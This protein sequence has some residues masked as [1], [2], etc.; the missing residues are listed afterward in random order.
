MTLTMDKE[1]GRMMAALDHPDGN[2][3]NASSIIGIT[4]NN[5]TANN[6]EVEFR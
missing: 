3:E 2:G 4:V 5:Q 1:I 6:F